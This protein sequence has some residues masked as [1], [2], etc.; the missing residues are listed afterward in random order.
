MKEYYEEQDKKQV[1][2]IVAITAIAVALLVIVLL[3]LR[4]GNDT[5]VVPL[6]DGE[7]VILDG[8]DVIILDEEEDLNE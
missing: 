5:Q 8:G 4:S 1:W 2:K 6:E 7:A 3:V